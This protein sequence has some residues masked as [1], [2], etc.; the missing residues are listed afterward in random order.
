MT[1]SDNVVDSDRNDDFWF[2]LNVLIAAEDLDLM[3]RVLKEARHNI[4]YKIEE[5]LWCRLGFDLEYSIDKSVKKFIED[6]LNLKNIT[7]AIIHPEIS[8][9]MFEA[10]GEM[11]IYMISCL[12]KANSDWI[13]YFQDLLHNHSTRTLIANLA[14][15]RNSSERRKAI[16]GEVSWR[17]S[18]ESQPLPFLD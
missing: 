7:S 5:D 2:L 10:A 16:W 18:E 1:V 13:R 9:D 4:R 3:W 12:D 6:N 17:S 14:R 11:F 8:E 15:L